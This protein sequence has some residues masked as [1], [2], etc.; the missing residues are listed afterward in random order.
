LRTFIKYG[1]PLDMLYLARGSRQ[2]RAELSWL[3][4]GGDLSRSLAL[5]ARF[6]PAVEPD[7]FVRC[8]EA[9]RE[10]ASLVQRF[11]LARSVRS[12]L[13]AYAVRSTYSS[14]AAYARLLWEYAA[15]RLAG[16]RGSKVLS[17]GGAVIA[18]VGPEATGKST[19]VEETRRWL[20]PVF[21]V[22]AIHAGKPPSTWLTAPLNFALPLARNLWPRLRTSRLEGHVAVEDDIQPLEKLSGFSGLV[23][24]IRSVTLAWDRRQLLVRAAR[25]AAAGEIVISDRYPSENIGAMDSPRLQAEQAVPAGRLVRWLAHLE[26]GLYAQIPPPDILLKLNVPVE[27]AKIRN[28]DRIKPGKESDAYLESRHRQVREW[29]RPGTRRIHEID[30]GQPLEATI[31]CVREAVWEA[32]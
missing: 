3:L 17:A 28:R 11:L 13:R 9:L 31:Q 18:F 24:A 16:R 1:S 4:E 12:R 27:I 26:H 7:L 21:P 8:V 14:L 5:L 23:Y 25:Q 10:D 22:S 2:V 32:L 6:C 15:R 29:S 20:K 30:T 19:L